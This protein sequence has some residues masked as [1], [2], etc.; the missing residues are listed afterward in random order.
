MVDAS[1]KLY[2]QFTVQAIV[3][4]PCDANFEALLNQIAILKR[5]WDSDEAV[6]KVNEYGEVILTYP[7]APVVNSSLK[8]RVDPRRRG[9]ADG[10]IVQAQGGEVISDYLAF[11][12]PGEDV[13][14]NDT[15]VIGTR[16]YLVLLVD[17]LFDRDKLHH[18]Q[19]YMTRVDNL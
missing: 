11:T 17:E 6:K 7:T 16:E 13:R 14:P 18:L 4:S 5:P 1:K 8:I 9:G 19:I 12:C 10:F 3:K 15:I 2:S